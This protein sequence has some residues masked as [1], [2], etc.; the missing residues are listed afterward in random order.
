M[1]CVHVAGLSRRSS[2]LLRYMQVCGHCTTPCTK[3]GRLLCGFSGK[4]QCIRNLYLTK[5]W[6]PRYV[7]SES[8]VWAVIL[9]MWSI[10][11]KIYIVL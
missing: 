10:K 4:L 6:R 3:W 2:V 11:V 9:C 8:F 7:Y 1:M 5:L